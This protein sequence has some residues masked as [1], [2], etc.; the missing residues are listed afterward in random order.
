MMDDIRFDDDGKIMMEERE[1][2]RSNEID[3]WV[4][5]KRGARFK[6]GT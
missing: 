1:R 4:I 6:S 3:F 5:P 2:T